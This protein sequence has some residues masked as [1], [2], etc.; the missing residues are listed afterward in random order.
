[1]R[2]LLLLFILPLLA[3]CL[4]PEER[5][6]RDAQKEIAACT[7]AGYKQGTAEFDDCVLQVRARHDECKANRISASEDIGISGA[8]RND[9]AHASGY[10]VAVP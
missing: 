9:L 8:S 3:G 5:A 6:Q 2:K 1:M 7:K 4:S 10:S